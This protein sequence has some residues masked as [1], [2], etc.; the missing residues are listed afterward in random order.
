MPQYDQSSIDLSTDPG[1]KLHRI[2]FS[3]A[4]SVPASTVAIVEFLRRYS[5]TAIHQ[6]TLSISEP[7]IRFEIGL[8]GYV[9]WLFLI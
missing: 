6:W 7:E 3:S 1:L 5:L 8:A 9:T 4:Q 2:T